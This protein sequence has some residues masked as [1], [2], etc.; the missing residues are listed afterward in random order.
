MTWSA[1]HAASEIRFELPALDPADEASGLLVQ[2]MSPFMDPY[3]T[4]A[5]FTSDEVSV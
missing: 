5:P 2:C 4:C 1:D 3:A